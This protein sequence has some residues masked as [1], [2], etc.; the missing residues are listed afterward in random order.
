MAL[1]SFF[2]NLKSLIFWEGFALD[3]TR[4]YTP[5]TPASHALGLAGGVDSYMMVVVDMQMVSIYGQ[6]EQCSEACREI[7][8]IMQREATTANRG[9]ATGAICPCQLVQLQMITRNPKVIWEEPHRCTPRGREQLRHKVHVGYKG[10]P[11]IY[12]KNCPFT[13][14]DLHPHLI[15]PCLD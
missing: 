6:P 8:T 7:L 2:G 4:G 13:F 5:W 1:K 10:V 14:D 15:N 11:H 12:P 9:S 3:L